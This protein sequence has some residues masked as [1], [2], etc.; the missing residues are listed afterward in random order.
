MQAQSLVARPVRYRLIRRNNRALAVR[1]TGVQDLAE[2]FTAFS[3]P[4]YVVNNQK[5][6]TPKVLQLPFVR[7]P[8]CVPSVVEP[9]GKRFFFD[10]KKC[11]IL[12]RQLAFRDGRTTVSSQGL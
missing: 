2:T 3:Y 12:C 10:E 11:G 1:V 9:L 4:A 6:L 8:V 7:L 5:I